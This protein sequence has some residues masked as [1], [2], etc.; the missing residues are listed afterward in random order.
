M[1]HYKKSCKGPFNCFLIASVWSDT[2]HMAAMDG[3]LFTW[4]RSEQTKAINICSVLFRQS[5]SNVLTR[6]FELHC[7][8]VWLRLR[9]KAVRKNPAR[10]QM[11]TN[12]TRLHPNHHAFGGKTCPLHTNT[13]TRPQPP[14]P[15]HRTG[16]RLHS[17]HRV[18]GDVTEGLVA[19]QY[20]VH[21][22]FRVD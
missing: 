19:V 5:S 21:R 8:S 15:H 2:L 6:Y 13:S 1:L 22:C 11:R 3:P 14:T 12:G 20:E 17:D 18:R 9:T 7:V 16:L 4:F 10:I